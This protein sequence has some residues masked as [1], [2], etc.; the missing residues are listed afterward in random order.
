MITFH[1]K[2]HY[3]SGVTK[4]RSLLKSITWRIVGTL[5]TMMISYLLT[6]KLNIAL[7][8]GSIEI[9]T[10]MILYFFHERIWNFISWGRRKEEVANL[11]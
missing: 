1:K 7:S 10:K 3:K 11:E 4:T 6:G 2:D 8:I 9:F 5:D